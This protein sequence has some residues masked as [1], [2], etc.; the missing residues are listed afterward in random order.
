MFTI[1]LDRI[2]Y[3]R[4]ISMLSNK[5]KSQR[6]LGRDVA[7]SNK[8]VEYKQFQQPAPQVCR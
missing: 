8:P 7:I 5:T 1:D 4:L 6:I 2:V 3:K